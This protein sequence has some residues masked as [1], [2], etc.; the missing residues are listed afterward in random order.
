MTTPRALDSAPRPPTPTLPF[1]I[2][3]P[4]NSEQYTVIYGELVATLLYALAAV[5]ALSLLILGKPGVVLIICM[6]VVRAHV[7]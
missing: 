6:A 4:P 7:S 5:A 1:N 3:P 2:P